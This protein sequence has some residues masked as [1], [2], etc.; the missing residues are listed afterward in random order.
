MKWRYGKHVM[1]RT[2]MQ[3]EATSAVCV[4]PASWEVVCHWAPHPFVSVTSGFSNTTTPQCGITSTAFGRRSC[5]THEN[6][7]HAVQIIIIFYIFYFILYTMYLVLFPIVLHRTIVTVYT[8]N[9]FLYNY[10]WQMH[11]IIHLSPVGCFTSARGKTVKKNREVSGVNTSLSLPICPQLPTCHCSHQHTWDCCPAISTDVPMPL[12]HCS[13][14]HARYR[15]SATVTWLLFPLTHLQ[16]PHCH[17]D[18]SLLMRLP[19]LPNHCMI[20]TLTT[21]NVP[22]LPSTIASLPL[23]HY[24]NQHTCHCHATTAPTNTR[25]TATLKL[26][27]PIH[28][29][30]Q[31]RLKSAYLSLSSCHCYQ[32]HT[33][34]CH[35]AT[36]TNKT[37][38][39][40]LPLQPTTHLPRHPATARISK[41]TTVI[42]HCYRRHT[43][44]WSSSHGT[45]QQNCHWHCFHKNTSNCLYF[46]KPIFNCH[47][48]NQDTS[49]C[50]SSHKPTCHWYC[51]YHLTCHW[52][53]AHLSP[54]TSTFHWYSSYQHTWHYANELT[55][56]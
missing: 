9:I 40:V 43:C 16:L 6:C 23:C 35:S 46:H 30:T 39:T 26:L 2:W 36:T 13:P 15:H 25:D 29:V 41:L 38:A 11:Q 19:L 56:D 45:H 20:N 33:C 51:S 53:C 49:H 3:Q 21:A 8:D 50:H 7:I 12:C 27:P 5:R 4:M 28:V 24:W 22:L 52:H 54:S 14:L 34:H 10:L 31:S 47:C 17:W 42:R 44:H 18:T 37:L 32:Q 48:C 1:C 55:F